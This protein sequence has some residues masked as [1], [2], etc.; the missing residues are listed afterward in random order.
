MSKQ[1]AVLVFVSVLLLA[2]TV[3]AAGTYEIWTLGSTPNIVQRHNPDGTVA[4]SG[5]AVSPNAGDN[6]LILS[7]SVSPQ[8]LGDIEQGADGRLYLSY[9]KDNVQGYIARY[10]RD[11]TNG[12][13][14]F[15][16]PPGGDWYRGT[17]KWYYTIPNLALSSDK[18]YFS[19]Y[20]HSGHA[21]TN[22]TYWTKGKKW[23]MEHNMSDGTAAGRASLGSPSAEDTAMGS[24][25]TDAYD[26]SVSPY[27]AGGVQSIP[28]TPADIV[29][30]PAGNMYVV[31]GGNVYR[32]N[33]DGDW[34]GPGGVGDMSEFLPSAAGGIGSMTIDSSGRIYVAGASGGLVQSAVERWDSDGTTPLPSPGES[35]AVFLYWTGYNESSMIY[36]TAL[37]LSPDED[38]L[39]VAMKGYSATNG[40][41]K[42]YVVDVGGGTDG[43]FIATVVTDG[44]NTGNMSRLMI[45]SVLGPGDANGDGSVD[46]LDLDIVGANWGTGTTWA[47]GNFDG[48]G[49][50]DILDLD[51]LGAN[52]GGG[53]AIPEPATMSLVALGALALIRRKR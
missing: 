32:F 40:G 21:D 43:D 52:W 13:A 26:E 6:P 4:G 15:V 38:I 48:V 51:I 49:V 47:Q 28:G 44:I 41:V 39:Y 33:S 37:A 31:S 17:S 20:L 24:M 42:S 34:Y 11:G 25:H 50:V 2:G 27:A 22:I 19:T 45:Y 1:H 53:E 10:D 23:I 14:N 9:G 12:D 16:D 35:G 5:Y 30:G 3:Q 36:P 18:I 7:P 29:I 8:I 46:I